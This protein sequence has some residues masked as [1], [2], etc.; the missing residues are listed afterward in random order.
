[1]LLYL[2]LS[3]NNTVGRRGPEEQACRRASRMDKNLIAR[4]SIAINAPSTNVW[5]ALVNPEAIKQYMFGTNA[6]SDWKEGSPIVWK[7]E[8]QGKSYKDKGVILQ[9]KPGRTIQYSHFS[10]LSGLPDRPESYHTVTIELSGEGNQTRV[11]LAQDNNPTEQ[12]RA[13]SEKNWGM[14]LTALKK[15][16]EQ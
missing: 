2:H 13:H 3:L 8:W 14:M 10:P 1:M 9:F 15:F 4:A 7:G 6:V 11:S 5:N 12:A 16:L